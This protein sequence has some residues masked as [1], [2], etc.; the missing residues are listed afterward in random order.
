MKELEHLQNQI[1]TLTARMES[2]ES[3]IRFHP[4]PSWYKRIDPSRPQRLIMEYLNDAYEETILR[5]NNIT[6][7]RY[8]RFT[9]YDVWPPDIANTY[10]GHDQRIIITKKS[11]DYNEEM[12]INGGKQSIRV[13]KFPVF[14][15]EEVV[16]V[17]GMLIPQMQANP[18]SR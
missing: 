11:M 4:Y 13:V 8:L 18:Y 3:F 12:I 17:G 9:D 10:W 7:Q 5:P 15:N 14:T 2:L 1:N 6:R 16:G